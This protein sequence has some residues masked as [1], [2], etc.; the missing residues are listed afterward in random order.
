ME[1]DDNIFEASDVAAC[2]SKPEIVT[3]ANHHFAAATPTLM[4]TVA[5][6]SDL[7][8]FAN[9]PDSM[10]SISPNTRP[11]SCH[12]FSEDEQKSKDFL[13]FGLDNQQQVGESI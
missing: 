9:T 12:G 1:D 4:I 2:C 7:G 13:S 5:S 3:L 10:S 11:S 8:S 6:S